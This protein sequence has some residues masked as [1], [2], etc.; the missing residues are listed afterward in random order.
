MAKFNPS[1]IMKDVKRSHNTVSRLHFYSPITSC[2]IWHPSTS[3]QVTWSNVLQQSKCS[4][5]SVSST[6]CYIY[7]CRVLWSTA[8]WSNTLQRHEGTGFYP[9]TVIP[10]CRH[11]CTGHSQ[12]VLYFCTF[13]LVT[14]VLHTQRHDR[15]QSQ[16][17]RP[18]TGD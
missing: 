8:P 10:L 6:T 1:K 9:N 3:S 2:H 5:G 12:V 16:R 7:V 18:C 13:V 4:S 11:C 17:A 15:T 14:I